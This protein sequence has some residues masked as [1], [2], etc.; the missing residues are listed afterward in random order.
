MKQAI[1]AFGY[2]CNRK[3]INYATILVSKYCLQK[4]TGNQLLSEEPN[5]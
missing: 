2:A 1:T 5:P 4:L 3:L